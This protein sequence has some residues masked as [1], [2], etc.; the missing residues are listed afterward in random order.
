VRQSV[1]L[2][3]AVFVVAVAVLFHRILLGE[4]LF[5]GLPALQFHPWREF[6]VTE[7]AAG[8]LP[9]WNPYN[10]A[11]APLLANYQSAILYPPHLLYVLSVVGAANYLL[12]SQFIGIIHLLW[13]GFGMWLWLKRIDAPILGRGIGAL[14]YPLCGTL[15]GRYGT[16]PMIAAAVWLPWLML[17]VDQLIERPTLRRTLALTAVIAC[18]LLAG[19]AQW[20]FYSFVLAGTYGLWRIGSQRHYRQIV[21]MAGLALVLGVG[22][23]AAQLLP[24]AELQRSS[25]RAERV[26]EAFA[27]N[28]SFPPISMLTFLYPHFFGNPGEG[29]Y[30]INGAQ[31]ETAVYFGFFPFVLALFGIVYALRGKVPPRMRFFALVIIVTLFF[32][33]GNSTP[34]YPFLYRNVPTFALFQ[35]PARWLLLTV[36]ALITLAAVAARHWTPLPRRTRPRVIFMVV[37]STVIGMAGYAQASAAASDTLKQLSFGLVGV[38]VLGVLSA[39]IVLVQPDT[40]SQRWNIWTFAVWVFVAADLVFAHI[41]LNP[42][43]SADF[44]TPR[45]DGIAARAYWNPR[46][47][48]TVQFSEF[49]PFRDYRVASERREAY[50]SANLPNLNLLD[51]RPVLNNFDPLRIEGYERFMRLVETTLNPMLFRAAAIGMT[52]RAWMVSRAVEVGGLDEAE[53]VMIT[54]GIDLSQEV[55]I[56]GEN[57]LPALGEDAGTVEIVSETPLQLEMRVDSPDG[58]ILVLADTFYPGWVAQIDDGVDPD[59]TP[60]YRANLAFRAVVVPP[61]SHSITMTYAPRSVI[62]GFVISGA[63]LCVFAGLSL[64]SLLLS[65]SNQRKTG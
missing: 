22:I 57:V 49:L 38:G 21:V 65:G 31:F 33:F 17:T 1:F 12:I 26:D 24:T 36:F 16:F 28:F 41:A 45:R 53:A 8:R 51:R 54:P 61:G 40:T 14:A 2:F 34:L 62:I 35:A 43:T 42:T 19:H 5:W 58:G 39:I 11:G 7:I 46:T 23:A 27:F 60:I 52:E 4:V 59:T 15:I 56:E 9:L 55:I 6:A 64:L 63:A 3:I 37:L 30:V 10:G 50:R 13:A 20:A 47:L 25:Q 32:A 48:D 44:Y 29:T 18:Q